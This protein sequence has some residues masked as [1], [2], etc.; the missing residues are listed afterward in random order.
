MGGAK[1][2]AVAAFCTLL[3]GGAH[4]AFTGND[5]FENCASDALARQAQCMYYVI[6]VVDG[7][8]PGFCFGKIEGK[9]RPPADVT[10]VGADKL[11]CIPSEA[12]H[13]QLTDVFAKYLRENPKD[14]SKN[15]AT[16]V[17]LAMTDAFPC[18][19]M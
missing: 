16:L 18:P 2:L 9:G 7:M 15:G 14:R 4:A 12:T 1:S 19:T 17:L 13:G 6:G 3:S 8:T 10:I 5:L 11:F